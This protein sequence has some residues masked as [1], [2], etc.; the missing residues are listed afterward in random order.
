MVARI[1]V[2]KYAALWKTLVCVLRLL[3]TLHCAE[4][5]LQYLQ[6]TGRPVPSAEAAQQA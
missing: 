4:E 2:D 5:V 1:M 3:L 6:Q